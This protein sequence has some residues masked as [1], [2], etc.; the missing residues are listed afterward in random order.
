MVHLKQISYL[1]RKASFKIK[2][3]MSMTC[4]FVEELLKLFAEE[5]LKLALETK[6]NSGSSCCEQ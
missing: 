2:L 4:F 6:I 3:L 1:L 5:D